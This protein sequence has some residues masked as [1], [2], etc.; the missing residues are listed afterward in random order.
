[1]KKIILILALMATAAIAGQPSS[2]KII[3]A[4]RKS[5][6]SAAKPLIREALLQQ[7]AVPDTAKWR[8]WVMEGRQTMRSTVNTNVLISVAVFDARQLRRGLYKIDRDRVD[9]IEAYV[10]T[11]APS[12]TIGATRDVRGWLEAHRI[13][14]MPV[15]E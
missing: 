10:Q 1:M 4:V 2:L 8:Q 5:Q 13:E 6:Q 7:F 9:E 15:Q 12:F 3:F 11:A 14:Q